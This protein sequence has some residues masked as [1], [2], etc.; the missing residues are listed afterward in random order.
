MKVPLCRIDEIPDDGAKTVDFFGREVFA[1][2]VDGRAKAVVNVCL[3]LG[4][5]LHREGEKFVCAW[6]GAEW[7]CATGRHLAGPGRP[8][9][10]LLTLPTRIEDG[11]LTYTYGERGER[12]EEANL[13]TSAAD[14]TGE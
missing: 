12:G 11:V 9:A 3:H 7:A 4:G 2:K 6:H 1:L 5:P 13:A 14:G 8:D 10:R